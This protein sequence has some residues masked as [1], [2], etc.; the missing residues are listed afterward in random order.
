MI[1]NNV[2]CLGL[3][4][5]QFHTLRCHFPIGFSFYQ[6]SA[7]TLEEKENIE[8]VVSKAWCVFIN[9]KKLTPAQLYQ[10]VAAHEYATQHTHAAIL[11]FTD[12][13]TVEQKEIVD[14]KALHRVDLRVGLDRTLRDTIEIIRKATMPCWDGMARMRSNVFN[15]GWYLLDIE[16]SGPD[17]LEDDI[18]SLS[19]SYMADYKIQSK[20]TLYIKQTYPI[21]E[22][23]ET[24]TGI[25]NE[26]LEQGITK[27]QAV[28]Y[29]NNLP[30]PSP[31]ILES[32]KYYLPF[33]KAL[34][35][36]CGQKF[37]LP[38]VAIDGLAAI[39]FGYMIFEKPHEILPAI[40]Q[41]KYKRTQMDHPYLAELYDLTLA[42]FE[43]LQ[44]R[45]EVRAAGDFHSLYYGKI[46][47]GE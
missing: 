46:E 11:L 15:D 37:D 19:I 40:K 47:C 10:I 27:A 24:I 33:L 22:Q 23:I 21:T 13:F 41:R 16:T 44:E 26:M 9:P 32:S 45:Y 2:L 14:T 38:N 25:T 17:P 1:E 28:E 18:I 29:L 5:M 6:V 12:P 20:E 39:A 36:S 7:D 35:H 34:Y 31:I 30:S 4:R 43:N 42:V 3:T 8:I